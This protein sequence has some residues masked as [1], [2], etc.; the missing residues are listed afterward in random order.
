MKSYVFALLLAACSGETTGGTGGSGGAPP[1]DGLVSIKVTPADQTLVIAGTTPATSTYKADGTFKDGHHEDVTTRVDFRLADTG[2]GNFTGPAFQSQTDHGGF[3]S[4]I[5]EA[6]NVQGSTTLTLLFKQVGNDPASTNL[7]PDPGSKFGGSVDPGRAPD[8]VYPN[9]GVLVPPNLG[10]LEFHFHAGANNTLFE[11]SFENNVTDVKI[12]LRCA[13]PLNGG[14]IYTPDP[15]AWHWIAETNRG[16]APLNVLIKGTDDAG[17]AVG[18]SGMQTVQFSKDN[19]NGGLYYWTTSG[20]TAI[21][22]FDF[23]STTQTTAAQYLTA[24]AGAQCIGCHALSHDGK[25]LVAEVNGQNDGRTLLVD[26]ATTTPLAPLTGMGTSIFES[27]NPAGTQYVGAYGDS[28]A[29]DFN[30]MLFDGNTAAKMADIANTGS[31]ANPADHPDWSPDGMHIVYVKVGIP[32]TLQK[33]HEGAIELI[34][35]MGGGVWSAPSEIVPRQSGKNH[36]YPA[37]SPDGSF[38]VYDESTCSSGGLECNADTDPT[39]TLWA[40][41]PAGGGPIVLARANAPGKA[42][43]GATALTDSFPKWSPFVF[44]RTREDGSKLEWVTFS[45]TRQYGLRPPPPSPNGGNESPTGTLIWM[46]GV[47]PDNVALGQDPS[48]PAFALPFQ[49]ITTSNHI[50]QWTTQVV[51]PP[52]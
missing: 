2:L 15:I 50:A 24:P 8:L 33:M 10:K 27:W 37:F 38:I 46:A 30:L 51:L 16:G 6:G 28:G 13:V 52:M 12:Y 23:A 47:N 20:A 4:V 32:N 22:R 29:T 5:A 25:K 3:T 36:Y 26:V 1:I 18:V 34:N 35:D 31:S 21:M 40:I 41:K 48:Y 7:P 19:I 49:D 44:Q 11:L 39:A 42:D 9:D 43:G 45:S 14:C 17:S